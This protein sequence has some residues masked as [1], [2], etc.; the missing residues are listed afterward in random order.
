MSNSPTI[1]VTGS[2]IRPALL[3]PLT[4]A[5]YRVRVPEKTLTEQELIRELADVDVYLYGGDEVATPEAIRSTSKLRLIAFYG[6]GYESFLNVE[7]VRSHGVRIT[8]TPGTLN[9]S[10]AEFTIGQLLNCRRKLTEYALKYMN[11]ASGDE[12]QQSDIG[13]HNVGI[14][15]MG[16]IGSR[17]AEILTNGFGADVSYFS[18][19][20][21]VAL[22]RSLGIQY[23]ELNDLFSDSES[24]I[25]MVPGNDETRGLVGENQL[26]RL[27]MGSVLI[28]TARPE[29]V[30]AVSLLTHLH[31]GRIAGAAFD[32]F[33]KGDNDIVRELKELQPS[34]LI[35][36]GH[37]ASL[38][39]DARDAMA[40]RAVGSILNFLAT[41]TDECLVV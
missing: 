11:G 41:G 38:T 40:Q 26:N 36:T 23:K 16:G 27:S 14:I 10:V 3:V 9:N 6:V 25:V 18:R 33:Y 2:S 13:N 39:N 15:G 1:L 19:T 4:E 12:Q 35:I 32:N 7:A 20:R 22:E 31:S 37:I 17:I 34:P 8:N 24:I 29:I 5:G 30:D 21:K 28:N